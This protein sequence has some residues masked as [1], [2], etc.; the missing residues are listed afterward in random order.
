M[1]FVIGRDCDLS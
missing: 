1:E